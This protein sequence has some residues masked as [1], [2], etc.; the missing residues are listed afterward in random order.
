MLVKR[1]LLCNKLISIQ[2][3]LQFYFVDIV[4]IVWFYIPV[5][6]KNK[7]VSIKR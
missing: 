6:L 3:N 1:E 5:I 7:A 4:L 2:N